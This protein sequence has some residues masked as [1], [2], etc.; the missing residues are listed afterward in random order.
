[1]YFLNRAIFKLCLPLQNWEDIVL[2][3]L[4]Y[5]VGNEIMLKV[6]NDDPAHLVM[7]IRTLIDHVIKNITTVKDDLPEQLKRDNSRGLFMYNYYYYDWKIF[8][9]FH[10]VML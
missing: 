2:Q 5:L 7:N 8:Y 1:M 10:F 9:C 4:T 3:S 6:E